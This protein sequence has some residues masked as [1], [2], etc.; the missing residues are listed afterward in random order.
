MLMVSCNGPKRRVVVLNKILKTI[1]RSDA[2]SHTHTRTRSHNYK[3]VWMREQQAATVRFQI[4]NSSTFLRLG[5]FNSTIKSDP[6]FVT[7]WCVQ[8]VNRS[9]FF[10][11]VFRD[12][13]SGFEGDDDDTVLKAIIHISFI[14]ITQQSKWLK[15][16]SALVENYICMYCN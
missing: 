11:F 13:S 7:N 6:A 2:L 10:V 9:L 5:R 14:F 12:F 1:S 3:C 4:A 15:L 16:F 8:I